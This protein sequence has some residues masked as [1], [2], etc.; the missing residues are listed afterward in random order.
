M[1]LISKKQIIIKSGSSKMVSNHLGL[2]TLKLFFIQDAF[3][4]LTI[5]F[6]LRPHS[7]IIGSDKK[8]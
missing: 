6:F 5:I 3:F 2:L 1:K 4:L 8:N 7:Y